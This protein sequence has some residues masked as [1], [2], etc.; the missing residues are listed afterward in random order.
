MLN[1]SPFMAVALVG[2]AASLVA[3]DSTLKWQDYASEAGGY[4]ISMPGEAEEKTRKVPIP[5]GQEL[6]LKLADVE[7]S[8]AAYLVS[9]LDYP[10]NLLGKVDTQNLLSQSL[11]GA[12]KNSI[13]GEI[14]KE[15]A[16][17][18]S[19]VPCRKFQAKGTVK[20][21]DASAQGIFCLQKSRL[22]QVLAIGETKDDFAPNADQFL[23]SFQIDKPE[24]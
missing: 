20:S 11:Q 8:D 1:K 15:E 13:Q 12:V 7:L 14:V 24:T 3:C 6:D 16:T 17:T 21:K 22:Y 5:G 18:V 19:D 23:T 9:Y 4:T 10:G 2:I